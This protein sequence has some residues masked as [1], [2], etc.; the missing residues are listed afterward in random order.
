MFS[1]I[2][3]A[4][5]PVS[6]SPVELALGRWNDRWRAGCRCYLE[7][8]PAGG[9]SNRHWRQCRAF[10][11]GASRWWAIGPSAARFSV[12]GISGS[13]SW[14]IRGKTTCNSCGI[15]FGSARCLHLLWWRVSC[16]NMTLF[17]GIAK[18]R[19]QRLFYWNPLLARRG[20][21]FFGKGLRATSASTLSPD[22][23]SSSLAALFSGKKCH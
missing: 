2:K 12:L 5:Y 22:L 15:F 21:F 4:M 6:T 8:W 7:A 17:D 14:T 10:R 13:G 16:P 9:R 20:R 1:V 23:G 19:G 11:A 3:G 18:S